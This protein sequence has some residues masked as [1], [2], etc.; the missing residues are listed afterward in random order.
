MIL[1]VYQSEA[2]FYSRLQVV[3]CI[4]SLSCLRAHPHYTHK[5]HCMWPNWGRV[6]LLVLPSCQNK[7]FVFTSKALQSLSR[8]YLLTTPNLSIKRFFWMNSNTGQHCPLGPDC[9]CHFCLL[10]SYGTV[11]AEPSSARAPGIQLQ[12][13]TKSCCP[14]PEAPDRYLTG[15]ARTEVPKCH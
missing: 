10:P 14:C 3:S 7:A 4:S 13:S 1:K 6:N 8:P 15:V 12:N 11:Q 5:L 9:L 2:T